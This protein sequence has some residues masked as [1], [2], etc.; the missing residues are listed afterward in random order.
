M[1]EPSRLIVL[2]ALVGAIGAALVLSEVP[3]LRRTSLSDRLTPH[4][5][6]GLSRP[7]S[8]NDSL[9]ETV[10]I[11][12]VVNSGAWL[13][14]LAGVRDSLDVR[15]SRAQIDIEPSQYRLKQ[16]TFC[17]LTALAGVVAAVGLRAPVP[18]ALL[19]I[20]GSPTLAFL[21]LEQ[22]VAT[23]VKRRQQRTFDELPLVLEQLAM[24][25]G[26]GYS[27]GSALHRVGE[28]L[29]GTIAEDLRRVSER[30]RHGLGMKTALD[31]WAASVDLPELYRVVA[32]LGLTES[33][34]LARL[35]SAEAQAVREESQRRLV[36]L[37]ERRAQ[38][39]WIPVTVATLVPG[40]IFLCIPFLQ[41]LS[42]LSG[43]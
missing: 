18:L 15:L 16:F 2:V 7:Q 34:D 36:E 32:V 9:V 26:A 29:D 41:A 8:L 13:S 35:V 1:L 42:L 3:R 22:Q 28:R 20:L 21:V 33:S 5:G 37:I 17:L 38:Q 12:F 25:L 4:S 6:A 14:R 31:E 19:F 10:L 23:A 40:V 27:I 30:N 24:L 43:T 11:P 39:V